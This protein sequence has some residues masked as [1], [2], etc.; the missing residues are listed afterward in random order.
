MKRLVIRHLDDFPGNA[1]IGNFGQFQAG[2]WV[3]GQL[4]VGRILFRFRVVC[5]RVEVHP[6]RLQHMDCVFLVHHEFRD[7]FCGKLL[8]LKS[9]AMEKGGHISLAQYDGVAPVLGGE[10]HV[11]L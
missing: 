5:G 11:A 4:G 8:N 9:T 1:V 10:R 7:V 6:Q 2:F 3:I